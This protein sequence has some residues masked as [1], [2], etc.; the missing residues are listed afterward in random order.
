MFDQAGTLR[1]M[2]SD[3]REEH[4]LPL[5]RFPEAASPVPRVLA[6]CG[7]KGGVGKTLTT[8]NLGVA[9]AK[10]GQRVLMLDGD[11]GLANLDVVLGLRAGPTIEDVIEGECE[12]GKVVL[13]GPEGVR[14][15]PAAS[16]VLRAG[17]LSQVQ[18]LVLMDGLEALDEEFD[19]VL[20]DCAAGVSR[21]VQFWTSAA[22]EVVLVATPEPTSLS[23]AYA[24]MKVLNRAT[25]ETEF[26]LVVNMVK[27]EGEGLRV[28]DR[29]AG[30]AAEFLHVKVQ[31]LGSVCFDE[32]VRSSVRERIPFVQRYPF[33]PAARSLRSMAAALLRESGGRHG[34]GTAQFFWR[35]MIQGGSADFLG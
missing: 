21:N 1:R 3:L 20:V 22:A 4:R 35:R 30:L 5:P 29:L 16:G 13:R 31:Y 7:G 6:I 2:M 12:L 15:I 11:F 14:V 32:A 23:D 9:L 17:E 25:S 10:Q 33:S 28:F 27:D 18:K 34:K 26:K 19:V 24:S 8:A